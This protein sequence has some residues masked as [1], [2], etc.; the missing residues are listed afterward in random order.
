MGRDRGG[1]NGDG[2]NGLL[3]RADDHHPTVADPWPSSPASPDCGLRPDNRLPTE[4][5]ILIDQQ[6][7]N[8]EFPHLPN[9]VCEWRCRWHRP[10]GIFCATPL[11]AAWPSAAQIRHRPRARPNVAPANVGPNAAA[12]AGAADPTEPYLTSLAK[13]FPAEALSAL[14]L[15][16]SIEC[17][18]RAAAALVDRHYRNRPH[19]PALHRD[20][21][22]RG[23]K[24]GHS[25]GVCLASFLHYLRGRHA[26]LRRSV[27]DGRGNHQN[28]RN[29]VGHPLDGN[30]HGSR[31]P[32]VRSLT[33]IRKRPP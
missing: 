3:R 18:V 28:R 1:R 17:P 31:S 4:C 32:H 25:G 14:L 27:R 33:K 7:F 8:V 9:R 30:P 11:S 20:L 16:L 23:E 6:A 10:Y 22:F 15:V 13:L 24:A 19:R 26:C 29:R 2:R 21:G 12:A 5:Q